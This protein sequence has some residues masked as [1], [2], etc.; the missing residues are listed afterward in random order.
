MFCAFYASYRVRMVVTYRVRMV[1][2]S[3]RT[4]R[5]I[6]N[7]MSIFHG[8]GCRRVASAAHQQNIRHMMC[9]L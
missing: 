5:A 8:I 4:T 7:I 6:L 1:V 9:F 3:F 2:Q